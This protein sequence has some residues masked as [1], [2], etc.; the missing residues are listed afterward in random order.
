M[1]AQKACKLC[2]KN[3]KDFQVIEEIIREKLDGLLLKI[4][5]SLSEEYVICESCADSI[6]TFY[7]FKSICLYS[8]DDEVPF[9]KTMNGMDVEI[10][11]VAYLKEKSGASS[12]SNCDDAV[13]RLCL[14]RNHCVDLN[15]VNKYFAEDIVARCIPEVVSKEGPVFNLE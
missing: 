1:A 7:E 9:I 4:D 2:S 8:R 5:F 14:K 13:C 3:S 6:Y 11:E 15:T 10:V 12:I